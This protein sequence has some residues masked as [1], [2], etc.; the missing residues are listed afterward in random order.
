M[1]RLLRLLVLFPLFCPY[2]FPVREYHNPVATNRRGICCRI[3]DA[4]DWR[5]AI[6]PNCRQTGAQNLN[7]DLRLHDVSGIVGDRL[8][9]WV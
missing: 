2:L 1:V 6:W 7:A 8:P 4:A 5:L 9:A 3:S